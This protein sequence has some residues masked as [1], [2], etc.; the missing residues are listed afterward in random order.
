V[1]EGGRVMGCEKDWSLLAL[2]KPERGQPPETRKRKSKKTRFSSGA[3]RKEHS[4]ANTLRCILR[5]LTC[6]TVS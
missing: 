4:P 5:L 6:R 1:D 2:K 3:F